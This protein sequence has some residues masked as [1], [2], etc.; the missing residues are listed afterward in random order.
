LWSLAF[1][2]SSRRSC[3]PAVHLSDW[4][5]ECQSAEPPGFTGRGV[6]VQFTFRTSLAPVTDLERSA[7]S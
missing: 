6:R 7:K 2:R 3:V 1:L 4:G 5:H